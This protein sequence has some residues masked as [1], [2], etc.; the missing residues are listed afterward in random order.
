MKIYD[1]TGTRVYQ[2]IIGSKTDIVNLDNL[3][4]GL[5]LLSLKDKH[6]IQSVSKFIKK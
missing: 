2:G 4:P 5:H 6:G 3:S 1:V